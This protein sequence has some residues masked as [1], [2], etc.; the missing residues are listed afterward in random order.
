VLPLPCGIDAYQAKPNETQDEEP[1]QNCGIPACFGHNE[2]EKG[3]LMVGGDIVASLSSVNVQFKCTRDGPH[4]AT[5]R[6]PLVV[7]SSTPAHWIKLFVVL[8]ARSPSDPSLTV[9]LHKHPPPDL[10]LAL[11]EMARA[12]GEGKRAK[13]EGKDEGLDMLARPFLDTDTLADLIVELPCD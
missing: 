3:S 1:R 8:Y 4:C 13:G 6:G 2:A 11:C 5:R 10:L 12:A 9:K 7:R